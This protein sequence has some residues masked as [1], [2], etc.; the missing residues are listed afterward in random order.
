MSR[1]R[2]NKTHFEIRPPDS[3]QL[4]S[5]LQGIFPTF[6]DQNLEEEVNTPGHASLH[7][8]MQQFT[9]YFG[10]NRSQFSVRQ[11]ESLGQFLDEAVSVN[12]DLENAVSTCMLE[13]LRQIDS[14]KTLA[15]YISKET[16]LRTRA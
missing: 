12:D 5:A 3:S 13:H 10:C 11:L 16:K 8:V 14:Y 9:I 6:R 4:L 15:P 2:S 7:A 1:K